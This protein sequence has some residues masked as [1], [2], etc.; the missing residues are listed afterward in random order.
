MRNLIHVA[1]VGNLF[2]ASVA[3]AQ[4]AV[5]WKVIDGGNGHWYVHVPQGLDWP[6]ARAAAE[7]VHGHLATTANAAEN[8]FIASL[9]T[10]HEAWIGGFQQLGTCEP[11]CDWRWVTDEPWD[12]SGWAPGEPNDW[13]SGEDGVMLWPSGQW[14]DGMTWV[15]ATYVIEWSADCNGDGIVDYGQILAGQL[16]DRDS[17][18]VPDMCQSLSCAHADFSHDGKVD[19]D[20][21]GYLLS[22][23][24]ACTN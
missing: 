12:F 14:N 10:S 13:G 20:D 4:Q 11:G 5:Q 24:G 17:D 18:G 2:A 1:V 7:S 8:A 21:L 9:V 6:S 23:W 16:R 3:Q 22:Q 15:G 19:G